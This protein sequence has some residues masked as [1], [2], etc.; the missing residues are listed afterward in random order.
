MNGL[1]F[2]HHEVLQEIGNI[3]SLLTLLPDSPAIYP[4]WKQRSADRNV[5]ESGR[6]WQGEP[7]E[8]TDC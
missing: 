6:P 5:L 7:E 2:S 3:E 4:A 1:G 8:P